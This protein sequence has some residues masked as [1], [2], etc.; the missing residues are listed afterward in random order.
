MQPLILAEQTRQGVADFLSST[1]PATT[2]GF[3]NL[4]ARFLTEPENF[5]KGPYI[6]VALPFRESKGGASCFE[7][8]KD[9]KPHAHQ[10]LAFE[11][12]IG[13]TPH[14]TIVATGTGSGKTECFL[15]PVL[16]H[17]RLERKAGRRGIKA[18]LIYPMN[19][20][21]TDQASR[22]AKEILTRPGLDDITAGLYVGDQ[23]SELSTTVRQLDGKRYTVITDR[24]RMR[25]APPD[26]LLTNYK[27]LDFLLI[28]ARDS[29]LWRE[30]APDTLKFLVVDEIHTFD[31]AQGTDLACL[32]RRLKARLR[33]PPAA[34]ACVGTSATLGTEGQEP[35]LAFANDLF[36]ERFDNDSVIGEER[37]SVAEYLDESAVEYMRRP[38]AVDYERIS[39]LKYDNTDE[40]IA[41]Q[42]ALWFGTPVKSAEVA[43]L[44]FRVQLG[45][46][47]KQHVAFQN[48][49]RD[50][51]R[52]GGRAVPLSELVDVVS[53]RLEDMGSAPADYA[54]LSLI[55]LLA[56]VSH[57]SKEVPDGIERD[58]LLA[59]RVELW[60]RELRRMVA[61]FSAQPRLVHSDDLPVSEG[62]LHLPIVHCR[63]C[64][65]MGWGATV[66]KTE[67]SKL[68]SDLQGFYRAFFSFDVSTRFIFAVDA[69]SPINLKTFERRTACSACGSLNTAEEVSC[70]Y[71]GQDELLLVDIARNIRQRRRNGA[72][73]TVAHHDCPYCEGERTLT[74]VGAQAASLS[75]VGV[76]QFFGS[77]Y[78]TDKKLITF[79]DSVQDAAH[80]AGF[81]ESRTWVLNLRPAMA[82]VIHGASSKGT[83]L[84]LAELPG[85]FESRW[86]AE[87][88]ERTYIKTFLPPGIAW[89]RDY[90][91]LLKEDVLPE[92]GYLQRL[93]RRGL[94]W[95][96]LGEFAQ[97]AHL[98]R[99]LTRTRTAS[100]ALE[101]GVLA[102]AAV[103]ASQRLRA[104]IDSL[105]GVT[106]A[107]VEVFLLGLLARLRRVG[108]IWDEFLE[109]YAK[110][111][112]NIFVYRS[113]NPAEYAMLKTPRRPRYLSL[114]PYMNCESATGDDAGFYRDWAFKA[115]P[116][117]NR[118]VK[119]D[120]VAIAEIYQLALN[121][122]EGAG[123]VRSIEAE[124]KGTL[125]W[126]IQPDAYRVIGAAQEWRCDTCRNAVIDFPEALLTDTI[127]RQLGCHGHYG[128]HPLSN[129][130]FYRQ[131]YLSADIERIIAREHTGLL[132]RGVREQVEKDF[133]QGRVNLLSAT[134]T[135][136]MGID[137]G[138]LSSVLLCSVPPAQAN[139]LQRVGRAGRK[140]GNAFAT[141]VA[142]GRQHDLYFWA[143][144][145]EMLAGNVDTPGV[146][147]NASAVLERQLTAFT[148]DCWVRELGD[149]ARVPGKLNDVLSAI[150]NKTQ[151]KFPY[152]WLT[153]VDLNRAT[154]LAE[155]IGIFG[156]GRE[157]LTPETQTYLEKFIEG[158]GAEGTLAWKIV[159]R[160]QGVIRDVDDLKSRRTKVD[161]E[162]AKVEG[163]PALG[164]SGLE[165][166]KELRQERMA[167]TKLMVSVSERDTLQFLT[168]EGL[169]PNY[170]FPEQGVLLHSVIIRDDKR[171]GPNFED[172]VLT[173]EYERSGASAITEFAPNNAFYAEGRKVT[174]EQVDVSRD[175][176]ADWRFCRSC[177][178]AEPG[179]D[180]ASPNCPR[181]N[182]NMWAD[183][184]RV[185]KMLR[186]TKVYARTL[187][188]TSRIGD[189]ADDRERHFYVRQALVDV[190]PNEIR[191]AWM[192]DNEEYP[193]AFEFLNRIQ[194][195]EVNFGEQ[196][197]DGQPIEIAGND[198]PKPGFILCAECG[199]VQKDRS[200]DN[201]WR[202]HALYCSKRRQPD[203]AAQE[204]I[205]LYREFASEGM[206]LFLPES[207]FSDSEQSV[208]SFIAALQMGLEERFRGSVDHLRIAR[209]VR[210]A[211]GQET[212]RQYLVIYDS[213]PGGTGYL[214][215]L[216]RDATPLFDVFRLALGKLNACGCNSDDSK[217]GCY[218]CLYGYH[219]SHERKHVSRRTA[220]KLLTEIVSH[221]GSL[222]SVSTIGDAVSRNNLFD[223]KL[224][225][226]F[227]E[228]LR[229]KPVDGS[230]RIEVTEEIVRAKAGY[231]LS[232]GGTHW[233]VE[234][235]VNL[236]P[237]QGVVIPS[238]PDFV[239]WPET[240]VECL[241]IAVFL[242]GWQ[243]HKDRIGDDIAKRMA[244]A[245]S[246]AFSVWSLTY[247]DIARFLEPSAA[248]P[249]STWSS[250]LAV[251]MDQASPTYERFGIPEFTSFHTQTAFEQ[252]RQRLAGLGDEKLLR[253]GLVLALRV[254]AG[255]FDAVKY[256][257][258]NAS[259]AGKSLADLEV[260]KWPAAPEVG[261]CWSSVSD[262]YQIALQARTADLK[263]LPGAVTRRELQPCVVMRW[264]A[265]DPAMSDVD[266]RHL[267]QQWWQAANLLMPISNSWAVADVGCDI[268]ALAGAPAYQAASR[269][270]GDWD[271][272]A[273]CA[274]SA[275]QKLLASLFEADV[276]AP[277]VGFEL[278]GSDNCV[279]A[280]CELAW[281]SQ[282]VAVQLATGGESGFT[283][284]GWKVFLADNPALLSEL[285]GLLK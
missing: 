217:D 18:I 184:G 82:Q 142:G 173:L 218:L 39:T 195:R 36:G 264:A 149:K 86:I 78:N 279:S 268:G 29:V 117:L 161:N 278:M 285:I 4:L 212:P 64:D 225:Q 61:T 209:D 208:Q 242:D 72:P 79:S 240:N 88:G 189:D 65:A 124:R 202:N 236:G 73:I 62:H 125:V 238:K 91:A 120:D 224:E 270:T 19:A 99:T 16:E 216:M 41:A 186:L 8:L 20:L 151:G 152:P 139:Y 250:A 282:K 49:L 171:V 17:C 113:N 263:V 133:K 178:Y 248:A 232:V 267:W 123:I 273:A 227:I 205:F 215:E 228:A 132:A 75:S 145:R 230:E 25:E 101:R 220:T 187:D 52:L 47:L 183:A 55:S 105:S 269:M 46:K 148:L 138:D 2:A 204:C 28:R 34:L 241:P 179:A 103:E 261:R 162:I 116:D 213:V 128:I 196:T 71:C 90:D 74:I 247:D 77:S 81:F 23:P 1:F 214:K 26:I 102:S 22:L 67:S 159:N 271:S 211:Q 66:T 129:G 85:A 80:R 167:L 58:P 112:C 45:R 243:Y 31:G 100:L 280:D 14:S 13:P 266:R 60:L 223:S 147:L 10:A 281:P 97:D 9:F 170:A 177:S 166:L 37:I 11:R 175:K 118:D 51:K 181:C 76:G 249:E 48:L 219:N 272:A 226:R 231:F 198:L 201:E 135:L 176:P 245:R 163:L 140:T 168:D 221:Q 174:I 206:R 199:T 95:A 59:V 234:P 265:D 200:Q 144:P 50:L 108:A 126:G 107:Q 143:N 12:L 115:L 185:Q 160:L 237:D 6:S 136:E 182:D 24:D 197:G 87:L 258:L 157:A 188:S 44:P 68:K 246:G 15:Y 137:I 119:V 92:D 153:Y 83:P 276:S 180:T 262:Q 111:G 131:L 252:L 164:D 27:M 257:G 229:R 21:A 110:K 94:T 210:I 130:G 127:C 106:D 150:R 5:A 274:A 254:G 158:S 43:E 121:A 165:E 190:A 42:Y 32:I 30:N 193:F 155:F 104:K 156:V 244:I 260:F 256:A 169:L 277:I 239:L 194:F 283:T 38:M 146:F 35:L 63:D 70:N 3:S 33:T 57:A 275:V 259:P 172:R 191:Q 141:T 93:V 233:R 69:S 109:A 40:Y 114:L 222:K 251:G 54:A 284:A 84:T 203:S 134:P 56:L 154:L 192:V 235:Q 253:L 122:L 255:A 7:W 96:M 89:L 98:G 207:A 53:R